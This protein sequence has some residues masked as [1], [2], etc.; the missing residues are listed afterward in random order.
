MEPKPTYDELQKR[1]LELEIEAANCKFAEE[2]LQKS[3][4]IV[5]SIYQTTAQCVA[6]NVTQTY[7]YYQI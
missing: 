3:N 7:A 2:S 4:E 5:N 6:R 1:V